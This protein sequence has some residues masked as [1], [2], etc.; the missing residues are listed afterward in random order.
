MS[1]R[2]AAEDAG[3]AF[4]PAEAVLMGRDKAMEVKKLLGGLVRG[5]VN[6]KVIIEPS[7]RRATHDNSWA[8]FKSIINRI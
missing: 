6:I 5:G 3:T 2:V 8:A 1:F 4:A 7:S